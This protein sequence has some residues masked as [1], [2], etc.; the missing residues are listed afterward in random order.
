M[1]NDFELEASEC[2]KILQGRE[3]YAGS[4][5]RATERLRVVIASVEEL[6]KQ[7]ANPLRHQLLKEGINPENAG[8][9]REMEERFRGQFNGNK[10]INI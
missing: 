1:I 5:Q 4:H 2:K 6:K 10:T 9:Y 7:I 3:L 8:E